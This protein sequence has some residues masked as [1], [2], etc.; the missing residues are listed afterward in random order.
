MEGS[1]RK[2]EAETKASAC[3]EFVCLSILQILFVEHPLGVLRPFLVLEEVDIFGGG[4]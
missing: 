4:D 2:G 1:L 3:E